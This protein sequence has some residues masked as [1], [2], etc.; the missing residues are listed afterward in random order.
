MSALDARIRRLAREEAEALTGAAPAAVL[1][2]SGPDRLTALEKEVADLRGALKDAFARLDTLS[3]NASA[4]DE[5][6]TT[7]RTRKAA[8]TDE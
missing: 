6:P 4:P 2:A 8:G 3:A 7:R 1:D 5:K